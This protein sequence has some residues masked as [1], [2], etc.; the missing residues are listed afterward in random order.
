MVGRVGTDA[1]DRQNKDKPKKGTLPQDMIDE[2]RYKAARTV[3]DV[4][5]CYP[6]EAID[7]DEHDRLA[8]EQKNKSGSAN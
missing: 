4:W 7:I 2:D 5:I 1:A 8:A 3:D 6:W